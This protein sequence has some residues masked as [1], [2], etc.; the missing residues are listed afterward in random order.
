MFRGIVSLKNI[1]FLD[2]IATVGLMK[3]TFAMLIELKCWIQMQNWNRIWSLIISLFIASIDH[4]DF[5][6]NIFIHLR[7]SVSESSRAISG[8]DTGGS[9]EFSSKTTFPRFLSILSDSDP[10]SLRK[11]IRGILPCAKFFIRDSRCCW[12]DTTA[13]SIRFF[14]LAPVYQ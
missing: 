7:E 9:A 13:W 14:V 11:V 10:I 6:C 5:V 4:F 2:A 1:W 3:C 12:T 8:S